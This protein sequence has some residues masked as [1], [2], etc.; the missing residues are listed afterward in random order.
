MNVRTGRFVVK[1]CETLVHLY[2]CRC[3][4]NGVDCM[5]KLCFVAENFLCEI[6][7]VTYLKNLL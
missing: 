4:A 5:E 7:F 3:D 1:H 6:I 2:R